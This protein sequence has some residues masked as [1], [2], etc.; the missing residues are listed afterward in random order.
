MAQAP[1]GSS[2]AQIAA[3]AALPDPPA[4]Y[5]Y[6]TGPFGEPELQA[7][8]ASTGTGTTGTGTT[9][10]GTGTTG[11]GTTGTGTTGTGTGTTGTGTGT[12]GT[13]TTGTGTGTTG[14]GTTG[15]GTSTTGTGTTT[16]TGTGTTQQKTPAEE[17]EGDIDDYC[18][19]YPFDPI[20]STWYNG[21]GGIGYSGGAG[22]VTAVVVNQPSSVN[23]DV[24]GVVNT[25]LGG[26]WAATQQAT[27]TAF[28][29]FDNEVN[30]ALTSI[31]NALSAAWNGLAAFGGMILTL[32]G[33]LWKSILKGLIA[34]VQEIKKLLGDL[35]DN[36]ITPALQGLAK[37]RQWL[38]DFY[39]NWIRPVLL[40]LQ[41][42]RLMLTILRAF[43]VKFAGKLDTALTDIQSRITGPLFY[44]LTYVN[45]VANMI[46]LI[47]TA[48]YL[49]QKPI[50]LWSFSAYAGES[51]NLQMNAMNQPLSDAGKAAIAA[52]GPPQPA[53]QSIS[54]FNVYLTAGTGAIAGTNTDYTTV[55]V[56]ALGGTIEGPSQ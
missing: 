41:W 32:L 47:I 4:G 46:N 35:M 39:R 11:T 18:S 20:C 1:P 48:N 33:S 52:S 27:D 26:L 3:W 50:W 6:V 40:V 7:I 8:P 15:T 9:G 45:G 43:G 17:F 22:G 12:T 13:G 5:Q 49:I 16:T 42:L 29:A 21:V 34:A 24:S 28:S 44:L 36:V 10:T 25:A 56:A 55:F 38:M 31:G 53:T 23:A 19:Q 14:T 54:D 2:A 30:T 37:A 51:I